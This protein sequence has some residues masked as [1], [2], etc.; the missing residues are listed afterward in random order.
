MPSSTR[1]HMQCFLLKPPILQKLKGVGNFY[2][3]ED[4]QRTQWDSALAGACLGSG[5]LFCPSAF[6][7][8]SQCAWGSLSVVGRAPGH[9]WLRP[10]EVWISRQIAR[11]SIAPGPWWPRHSYGWGRK[12]SSSTPRGIVAIWGRTWMLECLRGAGFLWLAC[13]LPFIAILPFLVWKV[14]GEQN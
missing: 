12:A 7:I 9:S 6:F 10:W 1:R 11:H 5:P 3:H 4:L 14:F 2:A 13:L 8:V